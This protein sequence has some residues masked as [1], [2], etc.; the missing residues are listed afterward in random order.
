MSARLDTTLL[1]GFE[2]EL[3]KI[4][5]A[6]QR[7]QRIDR[8]PISVDRLLEKEREEPCSPSEELKTAEVN[9]LGLSPE[10]V[11]DSS[12]PPP[13]METPGLSKAL[14]IMQRAQGL[15]TASIDTVKDVGKHLMAGAGAGAFTSTMLH[16]AR[17]HILKQ[18]YDPEKDPD[19]ED[20][21]RF[22]ASLAGAVLG[23]A[24]YLRKLHMKKHG[25]FQTP[26][27][28]LKA[29]RQTAVPSVQLKS[30][31]SLRAQTPKI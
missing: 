17:H 26:G 9:L 14:E 24:E 23:G 27:M 5:G 30:G 2:D 21:S 29:S 4:A 12:Q 22:Y 3:V 28:Q 20:K 1:Q 18:P 7:Q 13:P 6:L 15:K 8:R 31:P 10:R 19:R 25:S 16:G 11:L